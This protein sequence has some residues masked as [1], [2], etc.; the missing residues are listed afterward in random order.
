VKASIDGLDL[1][2]LYFDVVISPKGLVPLTVVANYTGNR[3][4]GA[5]DVRLYRQDQAGLP[6]CS[7]L[8]NL[9]QAQTATTARTNIPLAQSAKFPDFDGLES[10]GV[11]HYTI[12]VFSIN[13]QQAI[14]AWGCDDVAGEVSWESANT[15]LVEMVDRPPLYAGAYDITSRFDFVSAIPEP[16]RTWVN[17]VVGFF[18]SPT[19][20]VIDLA[21]D[22]TGSGTDV[23]ASGGQI[24]GFCGYL[25]TCSGGQRVNGPLHGFVTQILDSIITG[26]LADTAFGT[27][28]QAGGDIADILKAFELKATLVFHTEPD[29]EG[30]WYED[31]TSESWHT[32]VVKW[33]LG[34]NCDPD[35]E[36]G[37][38]VR[39]F[40]TNVF[41]DE[42]ITGSFTA[43]VADYW[44]LT[45]DRHPLNLRYGALL[46]YFLE[47]FLIPVIIGGGTIDATNVNSY[48]DLLGYFVGGGEACLAPSA[49]LDCCGKFADSAGNNNGVVDGSAEPAYRAACDVLLQAGPTFL[50]N[51]LLNLDLSTGTT[52]EIGT[53][54]TCRL[55]DFNND[56]IV[57]G[58]GSQSQPCTWDVRLNVGAGTS[59]DAIFWGARAE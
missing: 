16:Y 21:C 17:Y 28:L 7:D 12:L 31:D 38:G 27:I 1:A 4:V 30:R 56:M 20:T 37:C 3:P 50:R 10:D 14:Q 13:P 35:T 23:C 44:D 52:F 40:G 19:G 33:T 15:V 58:I 9:Y 46:N 11:Q 25:Y 57:D 22:L 36:A 34:A 49:P 45:I 18:Q 42:L 26:L 43:S 39:Q 59:F 24:T 48:E 53:L 51:A 8:M 54:G 5:F 55:S 41:Q 29:H 32:V 2:P 47:K 6:D